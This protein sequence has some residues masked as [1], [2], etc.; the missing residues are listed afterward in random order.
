[1][2]EEFNAAGQNT[3]HRVDD[4]ERTVAVADINAVQLCVVAQ[5]VRV[6][7]GADGHQGVE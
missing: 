1:M 6:V 5:V 4:A 3:R 2:A 7:Q